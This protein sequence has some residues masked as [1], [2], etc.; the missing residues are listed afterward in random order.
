MNTWSA[1]FN[2]VTITYVE[3]AHTTFISH[4]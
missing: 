2:I 1:F 4:R 3:H